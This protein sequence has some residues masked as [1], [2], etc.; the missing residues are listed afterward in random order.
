MHRVNK[1]QR[2]FNIEN[3]SYIKTTNNIANYSTGPRNIGNHFNQKQFLI[4]QEILYQKELKKSSYMESP[5]RNEQTGNVTLNQKVA[6][7]NVAINQPIDK[8]NHWDSYSSWNKLVR[9][10]AWTI[11]LKTN[12]VNKNCCINRTTDFSYLF[13]KDLKLSIKTIC[14][15]AQVE[16]FS[17][18]YCSL[19]TTQAVSSKSNNLFLKPELHGNIIRVRG[20]IRHAELRFD[21]KHSIILKGKHM[22]SKLILLDL[23]F[24]KLHSRREYI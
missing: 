4:G 14:K 17:D 1:I 21:F 8:I 6:H 24:K 2:H 19:N 22:I 11:K 10:I 12:W 5:I 7:A 9:N 15:L 13:P 3:W 20:Q 18:E 16:S 23:H